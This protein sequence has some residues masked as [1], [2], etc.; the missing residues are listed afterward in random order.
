MPRPKSQQRPTSTKPSKRPVTVAI[1]GGIGAGKSAAL[2][3]FARHGAATSSSDETVHRLLRED[4]EVLDAIRRRWGDGVV[5]RDGADRKAIAEIVFADPDE[6]QWLESLLHPKV[7]QEYTSWRERQSAPVV[8]TEIPLLYET[9][10]EE[11]FDAVV[12]VTAPSHVRAERSTVVAD[13]RE[14]RLLP[15]AEKVSRADFAYV[16]DGTLEELDAFVADVMA[17]LTS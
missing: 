9:G 10:G 16:N 17:R 12:V 14:R 6:L 2:D 3:A 7:V 8:V 11:R 5:G 15:D 13:A 1:T 4:P